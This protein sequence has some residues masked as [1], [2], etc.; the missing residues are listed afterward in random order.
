MVSAPP[1]D[2]KYPRYPLVLKPNVT[3]VRPLR[4]VI[5]YLFK[6]ICFVIYGIISEFTDKGQFQYLTNLR[7]PQEG[8]YLYTKQ[9]LSLR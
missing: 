4:F 9:F 7:G 5:L 8:T 1:N 3:L 6:G 2:Q